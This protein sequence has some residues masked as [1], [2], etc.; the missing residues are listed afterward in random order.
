MKKRRALTT[1]RAFWMYDL[2][3]CCKQE[4]HGIKHTTGDRCRLTCPYLV[5]AQQQIDFF[6]HLE[7]GEQIPWAVKGFKQS[8][9][10]PG[11]V[12]FSF[13]SFVSWRVPSLA[14]HC[15][16]MRLPCSASY[17]FENASQRK[18]AKTKLPHEFLWPAKP[19]AFFFLRRKY[20]L[21]RWTT[22]RKY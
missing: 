15:V 10:R 13:I 11:S 14:A 6:S 18:E 3:V 1:Q 21:C 19:N 16:V 22:F 5:R 20:G 12:S 7:L 9:A 2:R 17:Q 8:E 4:T